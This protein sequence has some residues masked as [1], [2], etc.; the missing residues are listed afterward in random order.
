M[1][2]QNYRNLRF[3]KTV[4]RSLLPQCHIFMDHVYS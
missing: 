4:D 3:S 2:V 1:A